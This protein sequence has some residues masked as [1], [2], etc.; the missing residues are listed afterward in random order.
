M[1][2][3]V[4]E[5]KLL[6]FSIDYPQA[7]YLVHDDYL[8]R[9]VIHIISLRTKSVLVWIVWGPNPMPHFKEFNTFFP[10]PALIEEARQHNNKG[11]SG[12]NGWD[13]WGDSWS[14]IVLDDENVAPSG[15][16]QVPLPMNEVPS[17]SSQVPSST[18]NLAK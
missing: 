7:G 16:L 5:S 4:T 6:D 9:E 15:S 14:N 2:L 10:S 17:G 1:V 12:D 11:K 13:D 18:A 8:S 3:E